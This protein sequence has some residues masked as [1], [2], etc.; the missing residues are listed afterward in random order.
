V[1]SSASAFSP[2][3]LSLPGAVPT[4]ALPTPALLCPVQVVEECDKAEKWLQDMVRQL[5]HMPK[6]GNPAVLA[7]DVRKKAEALDRCATSALP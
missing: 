6:T 2:T 3:R 5:Q 1:W 4:P 7:A